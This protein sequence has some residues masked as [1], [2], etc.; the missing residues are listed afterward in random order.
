MPPGRKASPLKSLRDAIVES[1][2][3]SR[4]ETEQDFL[5]DSVIMELTSDANIKRLLPKASTKLVRFICKEAGRIFLTLA[6][7]ISESE[8]ELINLVEEFRSHKV[9][10]ALLPIDRAMLKGSKC[11]QGKGVKCTHARALDMF[12][13]WDAYYINHFCKDQRH[14]TSPVFRKGDFRQILPEGSILPFTHMSEEVKEGHFS[15]VHQAKL[16]TDH[17]D[18]FPQSAGLEV[19]VAIKELKCLP[20][21]AD[22]KPE[23]AWELEAKA[24]GDI[25]GI[26]HHHLIHP[27]AA[28]KRGSKHYIVFEWANGG[29][30]RDVWEENCAIHQTLSGDDIMGFMEQMLGVMRALSKLHGTNSRT[31]TALVQRSPG[32]QES[33]EDGATVLSIRVPDINNPRSLPSDDIYDSQPN[34]PIQN[35]RHG[36]L[37]PDNILAFTEESRLGTWKIAD[38][39]LAKQHE[40]ATVQRLLPTNTAHTTLHYEAPE[41]TTNPREPRSRRYDI[42]STGCVIFESLIWLLYGYDALNTFFKQHAKN[43]DDTLYFT[44]TSMGEKRAQVSSLVRNLINEMLNDPECKEPGKSAIGDL[45]KLV[46][47]EMLVVAVPKRGQPNIRHRADAETVV[48]EMARIWRDALED[49]KYLFTGASRIGVAV[50]SVLRSDSPSDESKRRDSAVSGLS[51]ASESDQKLNYSHKFDDTWEFVND[52]RFALDLMRRHQVDSLPAAARV[53]SHK[54]ERC[55]Q[56]DFRTSTFALRD[57]LS[58]LKMRSPTC[59][60][61]DLLLTAC[62]PGSKLPIQ[63]PSD[64]VTAVELFRVGSGF[65]AA[66]RSTRVL[67]ICQTG[68]DEPAATTSPLGDIPIGFPMLPKMESPAYYGLLRQ[69]IHDCD[70][71][72]GCHGENT[73]VGTRRIPTRL[74][75]VGDTTSKTVHLSSTRFWSQSQGTKYVAL[76][77]PWGDAKLHDHFSTTSKNIDRRLVNEIPLDELPATFKDAV[78]VTRELGVQY[79]W[80]DSLCIIQ[81]DD[82]D[83]KDEAKHMETVFSFAYCVIAASRSTGT[84]DGFLKKRPD[85]KFVEFE[86]PGGS[87]LYVCQ[88]IDDF[89]HH[90]IDGTLNKRGW[91][92]QERA[93]AR[94]TIYF[95]ETQTYW[96]CGEGI[97]CETLTKMRNNK[98]AFLGDP[99]FP[100]VATN[101]T[102]GGRIRLYE[103]LYTQYSTLQF[104]K[105]Y[106]RPTAIAGLE[107]RLIRA[108]GQ[109]GG[110]GIFDRYFGRSLL[111]QR[112]DKPMRDIVFPSQQ[113]RAPTWSWMAYEGGITFLDVPFD[114]VQWEDA[115]QI[116]SPWSVK[117]TSSSSWHT[118]DANCSK[119]LTGRAREVNLELA[120]RDMVYDKDDPPS[121]D[122]DVKCVVVGSQKPGVAPNVA[123]RK[124][125][126]LVVAKSLESEDGG[127]YERV[128]VASL[129][130]S[131]IDLTGPGVEVRIC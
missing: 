27:I 86:A 69:W 30:L 105:A 74:I 126:V 62:A 89:Q 67:S 19:H 43:S 15:R 106:D 73:M 3:V 95:T 81:G 87:T 55:R 40:Y 123:A 29:T 100:K 48:K 125:Y 128:G 102:K 83:F 13:D 46:R 88:A 101:S 85:R 51:T 61:C 18:H 63:S 70:S 34:N 16:R 12:H 91:V 96:E 75:D 42:W 9:T 68:T 77:H 32:L 109:H 45:L 1:F 37:K 5:P 6:Y 41:V 80:I 22:Y 33:N 112:G 118:G 78:K 121:E 97:R 116:R 111:W 104:T 17:Q 52:S 94:R 14:F 107:Q 25:S 99:A 127:T 47:D 11:K 31:K 60:F 58:D 79:L 10:D 122:R 76:S 129:R 50:P 130:G 113:Y 92:L 4:F 2:V 8:E 35:W 117:R 21:E 98:A 110:F 108:F 49:E 36:D 90:V 53:L 28:F 65:F 115:S 124:H 24:L 20:S 71:H 44:V 38:L 131:W 66:D 93:L 119:F 39:G 82:G 72:P 103:S 23:K 64:D 59:E 84:S 7:N 54:C 57:T 56:W 114:G 120:S 26:D